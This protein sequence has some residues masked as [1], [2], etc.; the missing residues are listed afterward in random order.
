MPD[1][2]ENRWCMRVAR[3]TVCIILPALQLN[4]AEHWE[5]GPFI[6]PSGAVPVI[7]P[8]TDSAF[9]CPMRKA[10]IHLE[11]LHTFNP[12]AVVRK[13]DVNGDKTLRRKR[14]ARGKHCSLPMI[15]QSSSLGW[16]SHSSNLNCRLR[17]PVSMPRALPSSKA[18]SFSR[19]DG[20]CI[21][22]A[23]IH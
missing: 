23:P 1:L 13:R 19:A 4:S 3:W 7:T 16:K 12:A 2:Y 22:V 10:P 9:T 21:T 11:S 20:S 8:N 6:R 17:R 5:L 18:W 15:R 14:M